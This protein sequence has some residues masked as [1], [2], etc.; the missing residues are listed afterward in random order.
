MSVEPLSA[1]TERKAKAIQ[2][3]NGI[4]CK[5]DQPALEVRDLMSL[6]LDEAT[7]A[8]ESILERKIFH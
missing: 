1:A 7:Y 4:D 2:S 3:R 8:P 6:W 5:S